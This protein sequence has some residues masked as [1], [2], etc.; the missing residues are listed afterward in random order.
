MSDVLSGVVHDH[1]VRWCVRLVSGFGQVSYRVSLSARAFVWA[2]LTLSP[3][4]R[5]RARPDVFVSHNV[6]HGRMCTQE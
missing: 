2:S 6:E 4:R 1:V 3:E 5:V